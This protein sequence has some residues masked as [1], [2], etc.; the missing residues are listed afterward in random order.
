MVYIIH[1]II[2]FIDTIQV[3]TRNFVQ[4]YILNIDICA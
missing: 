4:F 2:I 1:L 3:L